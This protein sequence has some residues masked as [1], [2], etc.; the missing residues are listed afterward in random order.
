MHNGLLARFASFCIPVTLFPTTRGHV[1]L[2]RLW[3]CKVSESERRGSEV[4][5]MTAQND[6]RSNIMENTGFWIC[7]RTQRSARSFCI[8]LHTCNFVSSHPRTYLNRLWVCK[9][10][11]SE[12][13]GSEVQNLVF[14]I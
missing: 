11:E 5:I 9:M 6:Y 3:V 8:L 12:R 4:G 2:N 7:H 14:S 13:R 10:S 1:C